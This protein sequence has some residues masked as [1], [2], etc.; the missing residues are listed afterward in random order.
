[1]DASLLVVA[2]DLTGANDTSVTFA[3]AGFA[4]VLALSADTLPDALQA[5]AEVFAVSTD[6]RPLPDSAAAETAR[7]IALA[8]EKGLARL[9]LKIDSTMRGS[10]AE[11]IAGALKAWHAVYPDAQ[12]IVCPAYPAMGRTIE[13]G[14]LLV[15]GVPVNDTPSGRDAICPVPTAQ[16]AELLPDAVMMPC[17]EAHVLADAIRQ[18]GAAQIVVDG[19][20]DGDLQCIAEAVALLGHSAIPVGSAGLARAVASTLPPAKGQNL[21]TPLPLNAPALLLVTSI[22]DTSQQQVDAYIGSVA[23]EDAIVFSPHPAQLLASGSLPAL[24]RQLQALLVS[25]DGTVIIRANPARIASGTAAE[26]LA[27][28]FAQKLAALGQLCLQKRRFGAL[29]MF[30]GDGSAALLHALNVKALQVLRPLAEGVPLATVHGGN[31]D[32]LTVI[33]K[34]G[35]FGSPDLLCQMMGKLKEK[36]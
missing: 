36:S 14:R 8:R 35:G 30:G 31:Y 5:E 25:G 29:V 3:E 13:N 34:S 2:D 9:Y 27:R 15:N 6:C 1:M 18:S 21:V 26:T 10:V 16:M 11:Q 19:K 12:A 17:Q 22:H 23:G 4:T 7:V 20:N 28:H 24:M 33:T 32:G